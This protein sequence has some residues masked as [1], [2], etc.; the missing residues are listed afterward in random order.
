MTGAELQAID[1]QE[2]ARRLPS[3]TIFARVSPEQ[4]SRI[5]GL[6]RRLGVDVPFWA[7][8]SPTRWPSTVLTSGSRSTP[9]ATWPKEAADVVLLGK[10][11]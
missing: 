4:K 9:L 7:T 3:T 11:L 10:D 1:D 8:A 6:Q 5:I 2:L